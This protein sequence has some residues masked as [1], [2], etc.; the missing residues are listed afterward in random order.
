M[1]GCKQGR[2]HHTYTHTVPTP[3]QT[4]THKKNQKKKHPP[5]IKKKLGRRRRMKNEGWNLS[6]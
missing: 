5:K 3:S 4:L 6:T 2:E 1:V